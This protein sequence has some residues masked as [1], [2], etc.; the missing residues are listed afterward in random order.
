MEENRRLL[1][2]LEGWKDEAPATLLVDVPTVSGAGDPEQI[3]LHLQ[4]SA[5]SFWLNRSSGSEALIRG[6]RPR[7]QLGGPDRLNWTRVS[8]SG[9]SLPPKT[10]REFGSFWNDLNQRGVTAHC[11]Y[12]LS[13]SV[14]VHSDAG[15]VKAGWTD[16]RDLP[17]NPRSQGHTAHVAGVLCSS[18]ST[19]KPHF[20]VE[21]NSGR[22]FVIEY[23][24]IVARARTLSPWLPV[25]KNF[26][27]NRKSYEKDFPEL[28][29][30]TEGYEDLDLKQMV[31]HL[32]LLGRLSDEQVTVS[33]LQARKRAIADAGP[34]T[35]LLL[36]CWLLAHLT[37]F[38]PFRAENALAPWVGLYSQLWIRL[39]VVGVSVGL[40]VWAVVQVN[41]TFPPLSWWPFR[42]PVL[43]SVL[44]LAAYAGWLVYRLPRLE[45]AEDSDISKN[46]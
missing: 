12:E 15:V 38:K 29:E 1:S 9:G 39:G 37:A 13:S 28:S 45:R 31:R 44:V 43:F 19:Q 30:L 6:A 23:E 21:D 34:W 25:V 26:S 11:V 2:G 32:E 24:P 22:Q 36:Q 33:F 42:A 20:C 16:I 8:E 14:V 7:A 46:T 35:I 5:V 17:P 10:L 40:P 4:T 27:P 18:S 41:A 3:E